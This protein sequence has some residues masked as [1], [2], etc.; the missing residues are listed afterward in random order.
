M[1]KG[2]C[3]DTSCKLWHVAGTRRAASNLDPTLGHQVGTKGQAAGRTPSK[4]IP[5]DFFRFPPIMEGG[6]DASHGC[7][8]INGFKISHPITQ[9]LLDGTAIN[10]GTQPCA[11]PELLQ[12]SSGRTEKCHGNTSPSGSTDGPNCHVTL[13][14]IALLNI[15]GLK[16]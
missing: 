13:T 5:K 11:P 12:S 15:Q 10:G 6:N 8:N 3:T 4:E 16:P 14:N 7:Q 9:P 1:T 2:Q